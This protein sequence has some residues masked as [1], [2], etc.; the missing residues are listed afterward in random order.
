MSDKERARRV[1]EIE[2]G[3]MSAEEL[4]WALRGVNRAAAEVDQALANRI[5]LRLGDYSAM[6]HVMSQEGAPLGP[7]ELGNRLGI[8]TGS[9]TEL[10]DR[11]ERAG[12]LVRLREGKDRRR[13]SLR[14][15]EEAVERILTE[16]RPLFDSLDALTDDFTPAEQSA[17]HRYLRLAAQQLTDFADE[18]GQAVRT[19]RPQSPQRDL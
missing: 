16:L 14:P 10:V 9:A 13:V 6:G 8:S 1:E 11:L 5:G 4:S 3:R 7:V 2:R 19:E 12:H 18:L 15:S 17:I